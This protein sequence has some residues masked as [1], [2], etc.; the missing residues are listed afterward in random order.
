MPGAALGL[1]APT[2][3]HI[4]VHLAYIVCFV[5]LPKNIYFRSA[6]TQMCMGLLIM[7][8][9]ASLEKES[10]RINFLKRTWVSALLAY[11]NVY[12]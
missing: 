7:E 2:R 5:V 11:M 6:P 1:R 9:W 4:Y 10:E 3:I 8:K 12:F